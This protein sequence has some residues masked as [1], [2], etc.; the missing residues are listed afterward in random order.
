MSKTCHSLSIKGLVD[1]ASSTEIV[2]SGSILGRIKPKTTKSLFT[3]FLLDVKQLK[4][5]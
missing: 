1:K 4:T 5:M 3:A 2:V